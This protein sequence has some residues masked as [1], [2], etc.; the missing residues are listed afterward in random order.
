MQDSRIIRRC[1]QKG[2]W[3][4]DESMAWITWSGAA[5][6]TRLPYSKV[7]DTRFR[8]LSNEVISCTEADILAAWTRDG[9]IVLADT[10][11]FQSESAQTA[12]LCR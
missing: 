6:Q 5:G 7:S 3:R 12:W 1:G 2:P 11:G 8:A 9:R 10:V 4:I